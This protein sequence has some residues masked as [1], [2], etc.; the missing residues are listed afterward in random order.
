MILVTGSTGFVGR[1]IVRELASRGKEL[2]CL[3]RTSSDLSMLKGLNVEI[4]YGDVT[5]QGS[6]EV[7]LENVETVIHLVAIIRETRQAT[8][9]G[10]NY[11]GV[12]NLVQAAKMSNVSQV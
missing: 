8:L 7:V 9:E 11:L 10:V 1:H 3:A 2:K 6:L 12:R 4:C 5:N